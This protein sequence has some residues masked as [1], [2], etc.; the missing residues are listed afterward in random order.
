MAWS[1]SKV[2]RAPADGDGIEP[3]GG[4]GRKDYL[5]ESEIRLKWLGHNSFLSMIGGRAPR[6]APVGGY[7]AFLTFFVLCGLRPTA[8]AK[9]IPAG[10]QLLSF[11]TCSGV[12]PCL[13]GSAK[14]RLSCSTSD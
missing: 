4:V 3:A 10:S 2:G 6:P 12:R 9:A 13:P 8:V 7:A 11:L 1:A 14:A 5:A